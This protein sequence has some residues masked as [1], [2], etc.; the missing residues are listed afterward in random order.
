LDPFSGGR[1]NYKFKY[2]S[3]FSDNISEDK[4]FL[5]LPNEYSITGYN[6]K[7]KIVDFGKNYIQIKNLNN[8]NNLYHPLEIQYIRDGTNFLNILRYII[9][10]IMI[11]FLLVTYLYFVKKINLS[12]LTYLISITGILASAILSISLKINFLDSVGYS[13]SYL[14]IFPIL[15]HNYISLK[16]DR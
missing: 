7:D 11:L 4:C 1:S 16:K 14:M 13:Y 10:A 6:Y 8:V 9:F 2:Y 3:W 15:F 12:M 5:Q